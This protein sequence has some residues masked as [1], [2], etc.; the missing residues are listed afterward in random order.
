MN[1]AIIASAQG[2]SIINQLPGLTIY[3]AHLEQSGSG[4]AFLSTSGDW[5]D[6]FSRPSF[7]RN[8]LG[9]E[10]RGRS[11]RCWTAPGWT[12]PG[13]MPPRATRI[14]RANHNTLKVRL[15]ELVSAGHVRRHGD[16]RDLVLAVTSRQ[17]AA[18]VNNA[19]AALR[20]VRRRDPGI[21]P[22]EDDQPG[23]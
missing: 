7:R 18:T 20:P 15:R 19:G 3:T 17:S 16:A 12:A 6:W 1:T 22:S 4:S 10:H 23:R 21:A 13:W 2:I 11:P 8:R 9:S 5:A 14:T